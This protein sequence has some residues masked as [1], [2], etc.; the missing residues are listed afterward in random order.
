MECGASLV[1][2]LLEEELTVVADDG[3]AIV[4]F[5]D[6]RFVTTK[7]KEESRKTS[8]WS[9]WTKIKFKFCRLDTS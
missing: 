6:L 9:A 2:G 7:G 3:G 8:V 4:V 1:A 5:G